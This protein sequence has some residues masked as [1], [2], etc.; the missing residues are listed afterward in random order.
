LSP[1]APAFATDHSGPFPVLR[2]AGRECLGHPY[3]YDLLVRCP[4]DAVALLGPASLEGRVRGIVAGI[5]EGADGLWIRLVPRLWRLGLERRTRAFPGATLD[6]VLSALLG[7]AEIPFDLHLEPR[8]A[9]DR[10]CLA[11]EGALAFLLRWCAY[12]GITCCFR[13]EAE[14][15]RVLFLDGTGPWP[16]RARPLSL[17]PGG[18][19]DALGLRCSAPAAAGDDWDWEPGEGPERLDFLRRLRREAQAGG[20]RILAGSGRLP[21]L[22]AGSRIQVDDPRGAFAGPWVALAVC[23]LGGPGGGATRFRAQAAD[24]PFRPRPPAAPAP[25]GILPARL[26]GRSGREWVA[27]GPPWDGGGRHPVLQSPLSGPLPGSA[28]AAVAFLGGSPDAPVVLGA[29]GT[30][31]SPF[32]APEGDSPLFRSARGGELT[33]AGGA[34]GLSSRDGHAG[35]GLGGHGFR[36]DAPRGEV[37]RRAQGDLRALTLGLRLDAALGGSQAVQVLQHLDAYLGPRYQFALQPPLAVALKAFRFNA[38]TEV[39]WSGAVRWSGNSHTF[40]VHRGPLSLRDVL[41]RLLAALAVLSTCVAAFR[42]ADEVRILAPVAITCLDLLRLF[43]GP[44]ARADSEPSLHLI[45]RRAHLGPLAMERVRGERPSHT[46]LRHHHLSLIPW[47]NDTDG[48]LL[49]LHDHS[50]GRHLD[51]V[52]RPYRELLPPESMAG[53]LLV[54]GAHPFVLS[55]CT[56]NN[57]HRLIP[58]RVTLSQARFSLMEAPQGFRDWWSPRSLLRLDAYLRGEPVPSAQKATLGTDTTDWGYVHWQSGFMECQVQL[59]PWSTGPDR[60]WM[61]DLY[62]KEGNPSL[63]SLAVRNPVMRFG[64]TA[65]SQQHFVVRPH[66]FGLVYRSGLTLRC[67]LGFWLPREGQDPA[68]PMTIRDQ[69]VYRPYH[70]AK[71]QLLVSADDSFVQNPGA[72]DKWI[73]FDPGGS[74]LSLPGAKLRIWADALDIEHIG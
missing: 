45:G 62:H 11:G 8:P 21:D 29:Q 22:G 3:V 54:L 31:A 72:S 43:G 2:W 38:G 40:T 44:L 53:K 68:R 70:Q 33:L 55:M 39:Q 63:S 37:R 15:E 4:R 28:E 66:E 64:D 58:H 48:A 47:D 9:R 49:D 1:A 30:A 20:T 13:Q 56:D 34:L 73:R 46:L 25:G 18:G 19:L 61:L 32:A 12:E 14:G 41:P 7:E 57:K 24:R 36:V 71:G 59:K 51:E 5:R 23:H 50:Q 69:T 42:G 67:A 10:V 27:L 26:R 6:Q 65:R 60:S 17:A 35:L 74:T 16:E 52:A